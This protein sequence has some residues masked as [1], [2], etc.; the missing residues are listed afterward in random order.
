MSAAGKFTLKIQT[1]TECSIIIDGDSKGTL[2]AGELMPVLLG[3][4]TFKITAKPVSK[5]FN[6]FSTTYEVTKENINKENQI[7]LELTPAKSGGTEEESESWFMKKINNIIEKR[8][9][10]W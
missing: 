9:L 4:G 5:D 1:N 6:V 10:T 7:S 3:A 8:K 2:K